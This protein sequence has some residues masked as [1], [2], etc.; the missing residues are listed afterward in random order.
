[1]PVS[2]FDRIPG[3]R[4]PRIAA[5]A[6]MVLLVACGREPTPDAGV[7]AAPVPP[8]QPTAV[9]PPVDGGSDGPAADSDTIGGDGSAIQL[10]PLDGQDVADAALPGELSCGFLRDG[11]SL[12]YAIGTVA[13]EDPAL[14]LV[15]VSGVVE[16]VRAPGGY[17]GIL[18]NPTFTG[19]GMTLR[20]RTTGPA[21][22]G[23][24]SPPR[25]ATLTYQR[26]DGASRSFEGQWQCGP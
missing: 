5:L 1:M 21:I 23:G 22:G 12:L 17:D 18:D 7:E 16:Q 9:A 15:K 10:D 20:I 6:S 13:S 19:R 4:C 24:E 2:L 8:P 14:G 25:P 26:A 3:S 11:A